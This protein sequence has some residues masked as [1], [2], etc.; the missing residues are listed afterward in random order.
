MQATGRAVIVESL[1]AVLAKLL[2][3]FRIK[4]IYLAM[5]SGP[6]SFWQK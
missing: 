2:I 6:I 3:M 1:I 5:A 4:G